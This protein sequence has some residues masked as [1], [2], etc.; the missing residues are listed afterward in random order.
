MAAFL[1]MCSIALIAFTLCILLIKFVIPF[2]DQ[3]G[4][5]FED[6]HHEKKPKTRG[7]FFFR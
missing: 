7:D 2:E 4:F 1:V 6:H 3:F 5:P